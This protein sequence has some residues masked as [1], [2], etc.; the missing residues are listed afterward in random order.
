M[1]TKYERRYTYGGKRAHLVIYTQ[2]DPGRARCGYIPTWPAEWLGTG[3]Y[4]ER[5]HA[6]SLALC[7]K[8]EDNLCGG[9]VVSLL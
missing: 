1:P 9:E 4:Q 3:S 6:E 2:P 8:C 7:R 5:E